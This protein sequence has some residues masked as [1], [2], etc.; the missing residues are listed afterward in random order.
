MSVAGMTVLARTVFS[1][2]LLLLS[3]CGS[4]GPKTLNSDQL[5]YGQSVG[6]SWKNQMLANLVKLRFIDMPVFVDVGQIVSGYTF[7]S[8]VTG[9]LGFGTT[10]SGG[11]T[12]GLAAG[13]KYT[14]RPT[15]TYTP[16]TGEDYLRS[17]LE[18]IEPNAVLSLV[19]SGYTP[20]GLFTWVVQSI[21]GVQNYSSSHRGLKVADPE[22]YEFVN[23]LAELQSGGGIGF[24][25]EKHEDTKYDMVLFFDEE[26]SSEGNKQKRDRIREI[27]GI[28]S[29]SRQFPIVYSP[30][31]VNDATLAMQTRSVLQVMIAM[32]RFVDVPPDKSSW[33]A[34]GIE[35]PD[36][37]KQAF[38]IR[39]ST[40]KPEDAFAVFQ[41]H[42]DWYWIDHQD[43]SS[44]RVFIMTLFLTTLTNRTGK[45]NAPVLTIP[46]Q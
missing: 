28:S 7:E 11:N 23:L 32:S 19:L 9:T 30:F 25:I 45:P 2:T 18:P 1:L 38:R 21:N 46:T 40:E 14:D 27:L 13:S 15:I 4:F 12:Q 22:F 3:G 16:K 26:N 10:L 31:K 41:Y 44:K 5:D 42:G 43:V 39:T 34:T 20:T 29:Q 8:Q 33:A 36:S 6:E 17:L 35:V 37:S 24:E